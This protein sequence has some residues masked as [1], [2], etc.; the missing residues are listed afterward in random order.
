MLRAA[1]L[2]NG[3]FVNKVPND[4]AY[5]LH[6]NNPDVIKKLQYRYRDKNVVYGLRCQV[7]NRTYVGST[8]TAGLR[9]HNHLISSGAKSNANLQAAISKYGLDF[10]TAHIYEEVL[11]PVNA[12][13]QQ[14]KAILLQR[15]QYYM[16]QFPRTQLYNKIN[17]SNL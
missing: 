3:R 6:L 16:S 8:M 4:I 13:Y 5:Y 1:K 12:T 15:E 2:I 10:F 7:D 11:M 9:F 14:R 17:A